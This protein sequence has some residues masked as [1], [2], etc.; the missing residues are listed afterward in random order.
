MDIHNSW[1][2]YFLYS[3]LWFFWVFLFA[4]QSWLLIVVWPESDCY[5]HGLNYLWFFKL[6]TG[7]RWY[8][9]SIVHRFVLEIEHLDQ[10]FSSS[11]TAWFWIFC[12]PNVGRWS[13]IFFVIDKEKD[14]LIKAAK[15]KQ[16]MLDRMYIFY[17]QTLLNTKAAKIIQAKLPSPRS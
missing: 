12:P 4:S 6:I 1:G 9:S 3:S 8:V 14:I 11:L 13:L 16:P 10:G 5:M 2:I 15:K 7:N 17:Q